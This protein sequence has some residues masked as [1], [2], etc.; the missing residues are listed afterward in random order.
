MTTPVAYTAAVE[1]RVDALQSALGADPNE[2]SRRYGPTDLTLLM[3]ASV[4]GHASTVACLLSAGADLD[5]VSS[6]SETALTLAAAAHRPVVVRALLVAGADV[7]HRDSRGM[8]P[9]HRAVLGGRHEPT[10]A[11]DTVRALI[12]AGADASIPDDQGYQPLHAAKRRRWSWT[13]PLLGWRLTGWSPVGRNDVLA[14][15]LAEA[16]S[17]RPD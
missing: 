9:L 2:V 13:V 6:N 1:G 15:L 12:D 16:T 10:S 4:R 7:N 14:R 5:A 3:L 8:T 17:R 11:V